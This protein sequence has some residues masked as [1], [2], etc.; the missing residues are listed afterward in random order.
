MASYMHSILLFIKYF[1]AVKILMQSHKLSKLAKCF[2][3]AVRKPVNSCFQKVK[4]KVN[5]KVHK[6]LYF[7]QLIDIF[8]LDCVP[9]VKLWLKLRHVLSCSAIRIYLFR[10]WSMYLSNFSRNC[11]SVYLL[12][13][14]GLFVVCS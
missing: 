11:S 8:S 9:K 14:T 5:G 7:C 3:T 13:R 10:V 6:V 4:A 1:W 12:F 2:R